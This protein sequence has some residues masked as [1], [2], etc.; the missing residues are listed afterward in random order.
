M[1][2]RVNSL[3]KETISDGP[4]IRYAVYCQGCPHSCE[5]CHNPQTHNP[6]DG[7]IIEIDEILNDITKN[8][9]LDGITLSGGE[10]FLQVEPL[11]ELCKAV[12]KLSLNIWIYSG[13]TFEELQADPAKKQL[14][15]LCD[16]L[17]DGPF[18]Q[19]KR[20]LV[21]PWR[22]SDNQRVIDVAANLNHKN[23]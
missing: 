10:P 14:L 23:I 18:V 2:L 8:P 6:N 16:V 3:L 20:S 22:G 1:T 9:L 19:E 15:E 21:L 12:R 11:I 4:G 17:I 13:W 7:V 5:G